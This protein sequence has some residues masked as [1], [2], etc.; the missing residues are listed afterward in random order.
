MR[1]VI[2][3]K[4]YTIWRWVIVLAGADIIEEFESMAEAKK[5]YKGTPGVRYKYAA[6]EQINEDGDV[7]PAVYG[8]TLAE[9]TIK[10]KRTLL[11]SHK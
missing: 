9:V 8:N 4:D 2:K 3:W 10:L 5:E 1:N 6:A 11:M 7:N